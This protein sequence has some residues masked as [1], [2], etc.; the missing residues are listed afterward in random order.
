MSGER[1]S[2]RFASSEP[3]R[4]LGDAEG[5][6]ELERKL[7]RSG[8]D[9]EAPADAQQRVWAGLAMKIGAGAGGGGSAPPGGGPGAGG[10]AAAKGAA[11]A[12]A[13]GGGI[14]TSALI[15]AA[16]AVALLVGGPALDGRPSAPARTDAARA[17]TAP[18]PPAGRP[19]K[20][21]LVAP[22][23]DS[24]PTGI[25][26]PAIPPAAAKAGEL[27]PRPSEPRADAVD[28]VS[29][30]GAAEA[31][32]VG[33]SPATGNG[34]PDPGAGGAPAIAA[35][36]SRLREESQLLAQAR[37]ALHAGDTTSSFRLLETARTRFPAGILNQERESLTI[38]ALARN[39][40]RVLAAQ[41]AAA[42]LRAYPGSPHAPRV[43]TFAQ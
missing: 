11:T 20:T 16:C 37:A 31:L 21:S 36:M 4:W 22:A 5:A 35:R 33:N 19:A 40:N 39:G 25:H 28:P 3:M 24:P 23:V 15:G 6:S 34:S 42:F 38:E 17:I 30:A 26:A 41:R 18:A 10:G 8:L 13:A 32:S 9:A 27:G 12:A 29:S 1:D 43:R 7:L 2:G 14:V